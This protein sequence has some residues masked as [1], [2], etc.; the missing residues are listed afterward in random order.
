MFVRGRNA[1]KGSRAINV[2]CTSWHDGST[3]GMGTNSKSRCEEGQRG[4]TSVQL[5]VRTGGGIFL[6]IALKVDDPSE[7]KRNVKEKRVVAQ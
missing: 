1:I 2:S 3:C 6:V 5:E 4:W 7:I